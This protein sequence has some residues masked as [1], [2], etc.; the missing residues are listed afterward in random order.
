LTPV[1]V[2]ASYCS[3]I[4]SSLVKATFSTTCQITFL[5]ADREFFIF[6]P[7]VNVV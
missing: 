5:V 2:L 6:L 3:D 4:I 7:D 1:P